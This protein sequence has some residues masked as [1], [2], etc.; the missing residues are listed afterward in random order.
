M[1][2]RQFKFFKCRRYDIADMYTIKIRLY[3][4][5]YKYLLSFNFTILILFIFLGNGPSGICVSLMLNGWVPYLKSFDHPDEMLSARLQT[6]N[7]GISLAEQAEELGPVAVGLEGRSS[8]PISLLLDAL[9]HPCAD[10]GLEAASMLEWRR[11]PEERHIDHVVLGRGPPG[12]SWHSMDPNILTLSLGSWMA[13]PAMSYSPGPPGAPGPPD[14][15]RRATAGSVASY[16]KQYVEEM[17]L[18]DNFVVGTQ[19][20]TVEQ[21]SRQQSRPERRGRCSIINAIDYIRSRTRCHKKQK[22]TTSQTSRL[23]KRTRDHLYDHDSSPDRK[24]RDV[25]PN[26]HQS[27]NEL[28]RLTPIIT[29]SPVVTNERRDK[30]LVRTVNTITGEEV[31]YSCEVLI[32]A[33]GTNDLPN[34]LG[35]SA[36]TYSLPW[37]LH[38]LRALEHQLDESNSTNMDP[39]LI[40]GAGLSAADA[41]IATR[42]RSIPVLHVFRSKSVSLDKQLPENMYPEYH[43]VIIIKIIYNFRLIYEILI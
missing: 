31:S 36:E 34:R 42:F 16:Y 18:S 14:S 21:L 22:D 12:G 6:L 32:L 23:S 43:K 2:C 35:L 24:L 5:A 29:A 39:V 15:Q 20:L 8:N 1:V 28:S 41:V 13:L 33:I 3:Y 38:D 11:L 19:V 7:T 27:T 17:G 9:E 26:C 4:L 40:V 37:V 10:M 25:D 30:W